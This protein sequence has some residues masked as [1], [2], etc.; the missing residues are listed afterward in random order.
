MGKTYS[1]DEKSVA[2]KLA[3]EIG[4]V[5]AS[6]RLNVNKNTVQTWL[7]KENEKQAKANKILDDAGGVAELVSEIEKLKKE[8]AEKD[9][10]MEILQGA[11][12]FFSKHR[13]K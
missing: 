6:E 9:L 5:A 13:K 2:V 11:I 1:K 12:A 4:A 10:E 7:S 3:K 8:I